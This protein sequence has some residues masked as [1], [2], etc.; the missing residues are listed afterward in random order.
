MVTMHVTLR[1]G[2]AGFHM[3][4]Q[5]ILLLQAQ[6][7]CETI[8]ECMDCV[9]RANSL[10]ETLASFASVGDHLGMHETDS[11]LRVHLV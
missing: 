2:T 3:L 11:S 7:V 1:Q 10:H 9:K 4:V 5:P 8:S 6:L